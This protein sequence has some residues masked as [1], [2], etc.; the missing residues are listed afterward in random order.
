MVCGNAATISVL[1]DGK[2]A[3]QVTSG[4]LSDCFKTAYFDLSGTETNTLSA[5]PTVTL[6]YAGDSTY[7]PA[8]TTFK[9][10]VT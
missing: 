6:R 2:P 10:N 7:Q 8:E 5:S 1:I 3:G 9:I 4:G